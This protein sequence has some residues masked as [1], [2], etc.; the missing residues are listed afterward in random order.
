[1]TLNALARAVS[2]TGH[3]AAL[4]P[5]SAF[6]VAVVRDAGAGVLYALALASLLG[7]VLIGWARWKVR[8]GRW[9][10]VD[11]SK[12]SE[13]RQWN[14]VVLL[15]LI[16]ASALCWAIQPAV[17]AGLIA[18]ALAMLVALLSARWL[19]LSQHVAF[20]VLAALIA[21]SATLPI[22]LAVG[23]FTILIAWSRL[24]LGRH[25]LSEVAAGAVC[26]AAAGGVFLSMLP[27]A[28]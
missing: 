9:D 18:A 1:M 22:G 14:L 7:L 10:H 23:A 13:R 17:A 5:A 15:C 2:I 3:P 19:K 8:S 24:Q 25:S 11:A 21:A 20:A 6:A 28:G 12:P 4:L 16:V 27:L 26:G